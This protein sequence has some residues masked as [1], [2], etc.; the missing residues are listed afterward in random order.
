MPNPS[1]PVHDDDDN[2]EDYESQLERIKETARLDDE[3]LKHEVW[4][5]KVGDL[6]EVIADMTLSDWPEPGGEPTRTEM[7]AN[8]Q[9][10][11]VADL[12]GRGFNLEL[13]SG[14]GPP[15]IRAMNSEIP[16]R[17]K[18]LLQL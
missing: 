10:F 1:E 2:D 13:V 11:R 5:C 16:G 6:L 14:S 17:Y 18:V 9:A 12:K 15:E 4:N 3:A 7:K 8:G